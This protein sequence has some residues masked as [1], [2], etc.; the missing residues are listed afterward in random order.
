MNEP[1]HLFWCICSW[2]IST[3]L[4]GMHFSQFGPST[5]KGHLKLSSKATQMIAGSV[6]RTVHTKTTSAAAAA[7]VVDCKKKYPLVP[8]IFSSY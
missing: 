1:S 6:L 2:N 4:D 7:V 5:G 8:V 3:G